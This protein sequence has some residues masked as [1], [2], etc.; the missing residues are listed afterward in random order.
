MHYNYTPA[1]A[2]IGGQLLPADRLAEYQGYRDVALT[3][4]V[5]FANY[6]ERHH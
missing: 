2:F 5:P 1:G 6:W 3:H 4:A